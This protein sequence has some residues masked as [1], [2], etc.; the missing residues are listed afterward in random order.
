MS[1]T[2]EES[3]EVGETPPRQDSAARRL[4]LVVGLLVV[5]AL[6]LVGAAV[7]IDARDRTAP[8]TGWR[9]LPVED[10]PTMPDITLT[11]TAGRPFDLRAE[12]AGRPTLV[13]A[14]YLSCPDVCPIHMQTIASTLALPGYER[15]R[16]TVV[17]ID[18]DPERDSP[19]EV[20]AWLDR[21]DPGF[22]GLTGS[23]D[24][25]NQALEAM[26][27]P[28]AVHGEPQSDGWYEVD[29]PAQVL[30]FDR[31][32]VASRQ[33][34]FGTRQQDWVNDLPRLMASADDGAAS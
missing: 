22:V 18:T 19:E 32:G 31:D 12:T 21:W 13:Y 27:L 20:R 23:L 26:G 16:P 6:L 34:P 3:P 29:H 10:G 15:V 14:G 11:D 7:G 9:G 30:A 8:P 24:E 25:V 1:Q 5:A 2:L 28:P 4:P 17:F 33:Y